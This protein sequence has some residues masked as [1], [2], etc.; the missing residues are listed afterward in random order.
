MNPLQ[1]ACATLMVPEDLRCRAIA[2]DSG[3]TSSLY[4]PVTL[5]TISARTGSLVA[6]GGRAML[7]RK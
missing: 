5:S 2:P 4:G 1:R 7:M 3:L 6:R